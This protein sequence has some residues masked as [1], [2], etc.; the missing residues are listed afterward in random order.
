MR[1][2][3]TLN[4]FWKRS[5]YFRQQFNPAVERKLRESLTQ[6]AL[7]LAR[8]GIGNYRDAS[9]AEDQLL[10]YLLFGGMGFLGVVLIVLGTTCYFNNRESVF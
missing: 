7:T 8:D 6:V 1:S 2:L 10:V 3:L 9:G 5:I 4:Y